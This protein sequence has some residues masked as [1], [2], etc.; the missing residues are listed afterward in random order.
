MTSSGLRGPSFAR[1]VVRHIRAQLRFF[2]V[3]LTEF[4]ITL[5]AFVFMVCGSGWLLSR[6][7]DVPGQ[8]R[9]P[10]VE[11]AYAALTLVF[12]QPAYPFPSE[13]YLRPLF[14]LVPLVGLGLLAEG[15][16]RFVS[17]VINHEARLEEWH[18][19]MASTYSDHIIL[20]GLGRIGYRVLQ[21]LLRTKE[22]VVAIEKN[23]DC[24]FLE[25]ARS[26][27]VPVVVAD[28]TREAVLE[29]VNVAGA[30]TIIIATDDDL[31]NL[32]IALDARDLNPSIRV[33]LRLFNEALLAKV[34]KAFN[35]QI[36][37]STSALAGP[38]FASASASKA[39]RQSF[40]VDDTLLEVAEF[41]VLPRSSL[42]G[43]TLNDL[44][45]RF[46]MRVISIATGKEQK[47]FPRGSEK[48]A[49]DDTIVV[50]ATLE[51]VKAIEAANGG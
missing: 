30:R 33:V 27:G 3:L 35:I 41:T 48:V 7:Y 10:F 50:L 45:E 49:E 1:R 8:E 6:F 12:F 11:G 4:W 39:I 40:F 5:A 31:A 38:V 23:K 47:L 13:W 26:A 51:T 22:D 14:F 42:A 2:A 19:A 20:C 24:V 36:A 37:F 17:I 44:K 18:M 15:I 25:D 43:K 32:E 29:S 21:Q 16:V 46:P 28:P 34:K 9:L